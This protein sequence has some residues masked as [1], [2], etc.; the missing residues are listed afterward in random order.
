MPSTA[1]TGADSSVN[2]N[3]PSHRT[4]NSVRRY[5]AAGLCLGWRGGYYD[6]T[7]GV[8]GRLSGQAGSTRS[9]TRPTSATSLTASPG[10]SRRFEV[11]AAGCPLSVHVVLLSGW[12]RHHLSTASAGASS[13]RSRC[14]IDGARRKRHGPDP[15][16]DYRLLRQRLRWPFTAFDSVAEAGPVR[17][18]IGAIQAGSRPVRARTGRAAGDGCNLRSRHRPCW[19]IRLEI[20]TTE[21]ERGQGLRP[22][23]DPVGVKWARLRARQARGWQVE[24]TMFGAIRLYSKMGFC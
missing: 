14:L 21:A 1:T 18:I 17:E 6:G 20:A 12:R 4:S 13:E 8:D 22:P 15:L 16:K 24:A 19:T 10:A 23:A 11:C 7:A 5:E 3:R 2:Q 9:L